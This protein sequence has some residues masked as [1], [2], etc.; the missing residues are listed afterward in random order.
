MKLV[1]IYSF[2]N[3]VEINI[4]SFRKATINM[5]QSIINLKGKHPKPFLL[6][7]RKS[8]VFHYTKIILKT[9]LA[10]MITI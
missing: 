8:E 3:E 7:M 5:L 4:R 9:M 10:C 6:T 1:Y 2:N